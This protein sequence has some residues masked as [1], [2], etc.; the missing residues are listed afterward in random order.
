[1]AEVGA[2]GAKKVSGSLL[3]RAKQVIFPWLFICLLCMCNYNF[4]F[5]GIKE[6]QSL[7]IACLEHI[8]CNGRTC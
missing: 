6:G 4:I 2:P 3:C 7:V 1:M 8:V 5:H